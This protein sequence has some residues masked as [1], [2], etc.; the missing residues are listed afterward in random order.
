MKALTP[1]SFELIFDSENH[2]AYEDAF[3]EDLQKALSIIGARPEVARVVTH[4]DD[5][6]RVSPDGRSVHVTIGLVLDLE[7]GR[8]FLETAR[9][10]IDPGGLGLTFTGGPSLYADISLSSE[11]D[12]RRAEILAFPLSTVALLLVFGTVVA[13][14]LPATVG[15]VGVALALAAVALISRGVDMSVFVLNIVTL[16]GIGLGIDYSLFFT[17][18]FREQIAAGD[19]VEEAVARAQATAGSAILFSGVTSLIGLAS[20]TAFEFM[21]LRSVGIGAVIVITAAILAAITLMPAVLSILGHRVNAFRVLPS[22]LDHNDRDMWGG[23]SRWVMK[24]PL[25]IAVPTILFLLVLAAPVRDIR[26]GTVDAPILP[27]DL[28]SRRGFDILRD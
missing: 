14:F 5:P 13:A 7:E 15:G 16:L 3:T 20:L 11:K 10:L 26:L 24:R 23:L 2:G 9:P 28:E 1:I 6:T 8:D 18:R 17:S 4:L 12:V 25:Q 21:M 19:T 27:T 22:F